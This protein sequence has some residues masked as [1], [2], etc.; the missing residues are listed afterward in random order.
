[1][2]YYIVIPLLLAPL[3]GACTPESMAAPDPNENAPTSTAGSSSQ[4]PIKQVEQ[5]VGAQGEVTN[6]VL[7]ITI[8][9]TDI[10]E[11]HGPLG[12]TFTPAFEVHGELYFQPL[13]KNQAL[14]NADM[15]VL[16]PETNPFIAALL[17]HGLVFQAF[18]QHL[19]MLPQVWFIHF[20]GIGDPIALARA[21][22][23][24]LEVTHVR[25]PQ[26]PPPPHPTTPLDAHRLAHI[27][28]GEAHVGAEG[29]VTVVVARTDRVV[30][31]GVRVSPYAG[32]STTIQFK[33]IRR[34]DDAGMA[35]ESKPGG[36][37]NAQVCP[38]FSMTAAEVVPV[39]KRMQ[40]EH[41]FFQGSLRNDETN[42]QPQ[43]FWDAMVKEGDAYQLAE[44]I[45]SA[46]NLTKCK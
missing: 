16:E 31:E 9:R 1:M 10:G 42:E 39:V 14:L 27:L 13:G 21:T 46:L 37:A 4:M 29:V 17:Q 22:R 30:L 35:N 8:M 3:A 23:A 41:K 20:R 12:V 43:L 44:E 11:V 34:D 32:I 36:K 6:G 45:R 25:L 24:A 5:I 7:N 18:H 2:K 15:A 33:P 38:D 19:P 28:H 40:I 26:P